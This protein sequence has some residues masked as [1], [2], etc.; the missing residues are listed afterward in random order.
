MESCCAI[1][2]INSVTFIL[3]YLHTKTDYFRNQLE[4]ASNKNKFRL[5]RSL[6]GQRVQQ[7]PGYRLAAQGCELFSGFFFGKIDNLLSGLQFFN[8]IDRPSD[9]RR[10]FTD[11]IDVFDRTTYTEIIAICNATKK[12]CLLDPLPANQLT[13]NN[14]S[15]VPAITLITNASLDEGVMPKSLKHATVPPLLKKPSLDKDTLSSYRPVSN[16]T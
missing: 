2:Y 12:T 9:E 1:L 14:T 3:V 5:L 4:K 7:Q 8:D 10:C 15:I 13:D 11:C 6:D 16:L